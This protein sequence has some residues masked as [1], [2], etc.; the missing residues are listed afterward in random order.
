MITFT[1]PLDVRNYINNHPELFGGGGTV[2]GL[3]HTDDLRKYFGPG[4][5]NVADWRTYKE[6]TS[7]TIGLGNRSLQAVLYGPGA[8]VDT[9]RWN[10]NEG[11]VVNWAFH[12]FGEFLGKKYINSWKRCPED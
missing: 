3:A 5:G 6:T 8:Y 10:P 9:D 1:N 11:D 12:F 4:L 2:G 7:T